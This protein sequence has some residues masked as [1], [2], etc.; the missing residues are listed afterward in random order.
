[1]A[2][3]LIIFVLLNQNFLNEI[4]SFCSINFKKNCVVIKKINEIF[5]IK[6][7]EYSKKLR[8]LVI[9]QKHSNL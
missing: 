4:F 2:N 8:I 6:L 7:T 5:Q 1:M 9:L 3:N